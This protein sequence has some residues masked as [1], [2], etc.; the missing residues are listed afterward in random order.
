M[1]A[2]LI[3]ILSQ[4]TG[5]YVH[6]LST[7]K[8]TK[9]SQDNKHS[10]KYPEYKSK[11]IKNEFENS[12]KSNY[13]NDNNTQVFNDL[14]KK[15]KTNSN[16]KNKNAANDNYNNKRQR[17]PNNSYNSN[18]NDI[19]NNRVNYSPSEIN[20]ISNSRSLSS[21]NA[22]SSQMN[23]DYNIISNSGRD[24]LNPNKNFTQNENLNKP[25]IN[26]SN[27]YQKK[28]FIDKET[29]KKLEKLK[30]FNSLSDL[31]N[32]KEEDL[33]PKKQG[34]SASSQNSDP[35]RS[36]KAI[37]L[38][39]EVKKKE[40][41][42]KI[43]KE[44]EKKEIKL[45][46]KKTKNSSGNG[47]HDIVISKDFMPGTTWCAKCKGF[48]DEDVHKK[49][50]FKNPLPTNN[51]NKPITIN[52][53]KKIEN[54]ENLIK[55]KKLDYSEAAKNNGNNYRDSNVIKIKQIES[56]NSNGLKKK[57][58]EN[59]TKLINA[60]N[61]SNNNNY[62][63]KSFPDHNNYS[64]KFNSNL[65]NNEA[66]KLNYTEEFEDIDYELENIYDNNQLNSKQITNINLPMPNQ[67]NLDNILAETNKINYSPSDNIQ[68]IS[69]SK[70]NL[71]GAY[72][73][74]TESIVK[75]K[76]DYSPSENFNIG[77]TDFIA[78][79]KLETNQNSDNSHKNTINNYNSS[80]K[81]SEFDDIIIKKIVDNKNN[82]DNNANREI[83]NINENSLPKFSNEKIKDKRFDFARIRQTI[84]GDKNKTINANAT[85][86]PAS[87]NKINDK[88]IKNQQSLNTKHISPKSLE[89]K[90][91][92]NSTP[93][94]NKN[95]GIHSMEEKERINLN[96]RNQH[97]NKIK[98][99]N[100]VNLTNKNNSNTHIVKR[101]NE[102]INNK[103]S[104]R[105][106]GKSAQSPL[107]NQINKYSDIKTPMNSNA[108][109]P[110]NVNINNKSTTLNNN[111]NNKSNPNGIN[112]QNILNKS[113]NSINNNSDI[114][115]NLNKSNNKNISKNI[116][117][118]ISYLNNN[119]NNNYVNKFNNGYKQ[120]SFD[121]F[122]NFKE[123]TQP[124]QP[125]LQRTI[126]P[127]NFKQNPSNRI[128]NNPITNRNSIFNNNTNKF[129]KKKYK[130]ESDR[131]FAEIFGPADDF[132]EEGDEGSST[133]E[134]RK[135]LDSINRKLSRGNNRNLIQDY[136]DES[137]SEANFEQIEKEEKIS[138]W[139]ANKEDEEEERKQEEEREKRRI[140]KQM[141][142]GKSSD[143]DQEN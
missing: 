14:L 105:A 39:N 11:H 104:D 124:L 97:I 126:Y 109:F 22:K 70:N 103:K 94:Q 142:Q 80:F 15:K 73:D 45:L 111:S 20:N 66:S 83:K 61:N 137:I 7:Y 130:D 10:N 91:K 113:T 43:N 17:L 4:S 34:F 127:E 143:E 123:F 62:I 3:E 35:N 23:K 31:L 78:A 52:N 54:L 102:I 119:T 1:S 131:K 69:F 8:S 108:K 81:D 139:Y 27:N 57:N 138:S 82:N 21:K 101:M 71:I 32:A 132:I 38:L 26:N 56:E 118:K 12:N 55:K 129:K 84:S 77:K 122:D 49:S 120:N 98:P 9:I 63:S 16:K 106:E 53:E 89:M 115:N 87:I 141:R 92:Y 29:K 58:Y 74:K 50:A 25:N 135:Y 46:G 36:E 5:D 86:K 128:L 99:G 134:Y 110:N 67:I 136:S 59:I 88:N 112:K 114:N 33:I 125:S 100:S 2:N 116:N 40:Q 24:Y 121:K 76:I 48:H 90:D 72:N 13:D 140:R 19:Y 75:N 18:A 133:A 42:E 68:P 107:T 60:K 79:D 51:K 37:N 6:N 64:K 41:I 96:H 28:T 93:L 47:V 85:S 44:I 30:N 65:R 117:N 95:L